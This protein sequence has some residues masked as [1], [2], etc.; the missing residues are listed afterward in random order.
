MSGTHEIPVFS[1]AESLPRC[2]LLPRGE[3]PAPAV[4]CQRESLDE[5]LADLGDCRRCPLCEDRKNIV[6]GV[7]NPQ[8]RL[9]LVGEA[10]GR[11]EDEKGEPFVGEAGRLLDR[12]LRAMGLGRDQVYICNVEKCRPPGNRDP[13][14]EEIAACEPFLIRQL[15]SIRPSVIVALGKF[16][17]Q[18]LLRD[19]TPIT[20]LRGTWKDYHGIPL[21]P[22]YHPA[23]LLRNPSGKQEVW[24]DMKQVLKRLQQGEDG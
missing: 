4:L 16:A 3:G 23:Y 11:E 17:T 2:E 15:A 12:I 10:P 13:R 9:V 19:Q 6:F 1:R 22:T 18:T 24:E 7:G 21:M 20:R 8:A 5:I 14:P